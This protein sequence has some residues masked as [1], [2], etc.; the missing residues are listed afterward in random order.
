MVS[1]GVCVC[2]CVCVCRVHVHIRAYIRTFL[3]RAYA[4]TDKP[5]DVQFVCALVCLCPNVY[6]RQADVE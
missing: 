6:R 4:P 3:H 5:M 2:V 1:F